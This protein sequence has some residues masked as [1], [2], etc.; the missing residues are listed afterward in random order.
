MERDPEMLAVPVA[1][2]DL[3]VARWGSG[4][5]V[6]LAPHGITANLVSMTLIADA[7]G[8]D[9]TLLAPDL[10]GRGLSATLPGPWGMAAHADDLVAVLDHLDVGRAVIAGHSMGGF[11]ATKTAMR[12]PDRV[13]SLVLI[14][15]GLGIPVPAGMDIDQIL[16]A[17]VGAAIQRLDM[18]FVSRDAYLDFWRDHPALGDDWND[19]LVAYL[20]HDMI[21][22]EDGRWRSRVSAEAVRADGRDT[23]SD[24][25]L[26]DGLGT[27]DLPMHFAW[28][29]VGLSGGDPLYP[30]AVVAQFDDAIP[31][32]S[33]TELEDVN[34]YTLA[35][36]DRGATQVAVLIDVAVAD[37]A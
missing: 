19:T 31:N 3:A 25:S 32:L 10:R 23:L 28:A 34:H 26:V 20:D 22:G 30:R 14:D 24:T 18:T 9:I 35:L 15:G 17:V 12:H 21:E 8:D 27:I 1:G 6:V 11:V 5:N 33:V 16:L 4:P 36:T 2:G 29:P 37:T 7:V 13:R